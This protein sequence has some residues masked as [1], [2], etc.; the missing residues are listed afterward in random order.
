MQSY[1]LAFLIQRSRVTAQSRDSL[2]FPGCKEEEEGNK[3]P[4]VGKHL[5]SVHL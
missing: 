5:I 3:F 1:H 4:K 2:Y